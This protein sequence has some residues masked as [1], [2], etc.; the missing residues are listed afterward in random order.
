MRQLCIG[1]LGTALLISAPL[2]SALGAGEVLLPSNKN[3]NSPVPNLGLVPRDSAKPPDGTAAP[4]PAP[5]PPP[6]ATLPYTPA[7]TRPPVVTTPP[8]PATP[9][10]ASALPSNVVN[11]GT[12]NS[13]K[14][15]TKDIDHVNMLLG[16]PK[17]KVISSCQFSVLGLIYTD[18]GAKGFKGKFQERIDV[19]YAGN[20]TK[21]TL[22]TQA[23][24]DAAAV[25]GEKPYALKQ[26]N[27]YM[28]SVAMDTCAIPDSAKQTR[29]ILISYNDKGTAQCQYK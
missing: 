14:W 27:K 11:V 28:T 3:S 2:Y 8:K 5:A 16:I 12:V 6:A 13:Y 26:D 17:D 18:K 9:Y 1:I 4:T 24:C 29:Q 20:L 19:N 21:L 23:A 7:P 15:A 25:M 10:A 22:L